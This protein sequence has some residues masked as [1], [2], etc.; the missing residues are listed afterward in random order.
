MFY[1]FF[2]LV[3]ILLAEYGG[4]RLFFFNIFIGV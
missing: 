1:F 3:N 4:E 2:Y